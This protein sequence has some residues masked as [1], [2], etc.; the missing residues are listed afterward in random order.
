ME[1]Y[2]YNTYNNFGVLR[3]EQSRLTGSEINSNRIYPL[4]FPFDAIVTSTGAEATRLIATYSVSRV[5]MAIIT[6]CLSHHK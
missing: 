2:F 5:A 3:G 4:S 1:V 6:P